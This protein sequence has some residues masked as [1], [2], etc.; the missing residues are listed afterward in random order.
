MSSQSLLGQL[1]T[2]LAKPHSCHVACDSHEQFRLVRVVAKL[3]NQR[4]LLIRYKTPKPRQLQVWVAFVFPRVST[5]RA[6][7]DR[8]L[9]LYPGQTIA[10]RGKVEKTFHTLVVS[11]NVVTT[12]WADDF[13]LLSKTLS[14]N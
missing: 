6:T 10:N 13:G 8:L 2:D 3:G 7:D 5:R 9:Q 12:G 11:I 14:R 1:A 4:L